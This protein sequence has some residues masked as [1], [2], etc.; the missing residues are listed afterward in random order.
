VSIFFRDVVHIGAGAACTRHVR[1]KAT[2]AGN[3]PEPEK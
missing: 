2:A 3:D 1:W